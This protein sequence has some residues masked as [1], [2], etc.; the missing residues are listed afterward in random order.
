MIGFIAV[1]S[2]SLF[3]FNCY[4]SSHSR[5]NDLLQKSNTVHPPIYHIFEKLKVCAVPSGTLSSIKQLTY[6]DLTPVDIAN[7][8]KCPNI[9]PRDISPWDSWDW[10]KNRWNSPWILSSGTQVPGT[11]ILGTGSPVPCPSSAKLL[12]LF[13]KMPKKYL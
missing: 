8:K 4:Y 3:K 2:T 11:K 5:K 9:V 12:I 13:A 6:F 7:V 10:D 1:I